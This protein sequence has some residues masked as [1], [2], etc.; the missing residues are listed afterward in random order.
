[1]SATGLP[2]VPRPL[3]LPALLAPAPRKLPPAVA[4]VKGLVDS[5]LARGVPEE[6][7]RFVWLSVAATGRFDQ[8][9]HVLPSYQLGGTCNTYA[10]TPTAGCSAHFSGVA[11][12]AP[13]NSGSQ[14]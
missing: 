13:H 14:P 12:G 11:R 1:R 10:T 4:R 6:I 9:S 7:G 5:L 3:P 8:I 2:A